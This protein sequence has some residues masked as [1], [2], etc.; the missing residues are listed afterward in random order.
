MKIGIA[1]TGAVG[2]YFGAA[3]QRAGNRVI[4]LARGE[5][6]KTLK[7][8]GLKVI[9]EKENFQID[10]VFT[11]DFQDFSEIDLLLFTVKSNATAEVAVEI[12]PYLKKT[13]SILTLQNG[14]D[15][16][17]V[18]SDVF[19]AP[20]IFAAATYIQAVVEEPG[21]V[22]RIGLDPRLVIG[23]IEPSSLENA[24]R[25]AS[26]FQ[27][28]KIDT[29]VVAD[30]LTVKWKKLLWN[31]AFNPLTALIES[32]VGAIYADEGLYRISESLCKEGIAVART[33]GINIEENFHETIMEQG[34]LAEDHIT[35]M[36]QDKQK[37]KPMEL[38]SIC[39]YAIKKGR[40][41]SIS[42]PVLETIFSLLDYQSIAK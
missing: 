4:F 13:C 10:G 11:G 30:I 17:E 36:L 24:K 18:L 21:V 35:S 32:K 39:G 23:P 29:Y 26:A 28:A 34:K 8:R 42:T 20:R 15:N 19:G 6:L 25:I 2:G 1:G 9:G 27:S 7:Q 38:D 5:N 40:E 33:S 31:I 37:G 14:V 22:R 41:L 12:A 16:E 3:L